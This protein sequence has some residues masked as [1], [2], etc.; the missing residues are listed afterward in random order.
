MYSYLSWNIIKNLSWNIYSKKQNLTRI[1]SIN[2]FY[3]LKLFTLSF[4]NI[5]FLK[6]FFSSWIQEHIIYKH[7]SMFFLLASSVQ[8]FSFFFNKEILWL[9]KTSNSK[10]QNKNNKW[11][12]IPIWK[13]RKITPSLIFHMEIWI[14]IFS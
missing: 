12:Q 11:N 4:L 1:I 3:L 8:Y 9:R 13:I 7:Y 2:H 14:S 10:L 5:F 6:F